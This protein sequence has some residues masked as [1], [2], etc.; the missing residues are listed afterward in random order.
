MLGLRKRALRMELGHMKHRLI[1]LT[2]FAIMYMQGHAQ[3]NGNISVSALQKLSES[4]T[5]T[6]QKTW[7]ALPNEYPINDLWSETWKGAYLEFA[8]NNKFH[9]VRRNTDDQEKTALPFVSGDYLFDYPNELLYLKFTNSLNAES[10]EMVFQVA[11]CKEKRQKLSPVK[12]M[13][14]YPTEK[15]RQF[16]IYYKET[17]LPTKAR[18][19]LRHWNGVLNMYRYAGATWNM[20]VAEILKCEAVKSG[21]VYVKSDR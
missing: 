3:N 5:V 4:H 7:Y 9:L 6:T 11:Y 17:R 10:Y 19:N 13:G 16:F 15:S 12:T 21:I 14:I 1:I 2:V 18:K 20:P 8:A